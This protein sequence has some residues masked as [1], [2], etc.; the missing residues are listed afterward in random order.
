MILTKDNL[1]RFVREKKAVTH[2]MVAEAFET[3]TMIASAALSEIAK[4]KHIAITYL[5]G[6]SSPYYYDPRQPEILE[7]IG[8]K[9]L[10]KGEKEI[11]LK[12]KNSQVLSDNSLSI[13]E[14]LCIEKIK[15]FAIPLEI[16]HQDKELKF[17]VW[18][19]RDIK[20]TR[21]QIMDALK[22]QKTEEP[23]KKPEPKREVRTQMPQSIQREVRTVS[24]NIPSQRVMPQNTIHNNM[25][26]SSNRP[27]MNLEVESNPYEMFIENFLRQNY[28]KVISKINRK[29]G[30]LYS[31]NLDLGKLK[32]HLDCFYY[33][34]KP[35]DADLIKFYTSS[36]KPKIVFI[37]KCPQ[38]LLKLAQKV[39]N[40]T[41]VN[42]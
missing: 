33:F 14:R 22:P 25:A 39:E 3:S 30:I 9:Q 23:P 1:L 12:L 19:R 13:Q 21:T 40:L 28:L 35:T 36:Q 10:S 20:E 16:A 34:K 32:L 31:V 11:F 8:E 26:G 41:I 29:D 24:N 17:W 38:K 6:A 15:D 4:E 37:E 18:Y 2:A 27:N 7:E 42:I 5:K